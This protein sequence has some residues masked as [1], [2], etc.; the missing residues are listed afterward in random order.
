LKILTARAATRRT[1]TDDT[2]ASDSIKP[3]ARRVSGNVSV[4][5]KA[6]EFVKETY[7]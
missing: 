4:G 2:E 3:L 7:R 5:L 1:V 6:I